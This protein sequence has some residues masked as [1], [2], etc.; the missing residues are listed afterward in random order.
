MMVR[1]NPDVSPPETDKNQGHGLIIVLPYCSASIYVCIFKTNKHLFSHVFIFSPVW[2]PVVVSVWEQ[3][4]VRSGEKQER[5]SRNARWGTRVE[6]GMMQTYV[7]AVLLTLQQSV[8]VPDSCSVFLGGRGFR[9]PIRTGV[10]TVKIGGRPWPIGASR[11]FV[12]WIWRSARPACWRAF[13]LMFHLDRW[14]CR[15]LRHWT[16]NVQT[17]Y[18]VSN[19]HTN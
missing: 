11:Q 1:W 16:L 3:T 10:C 13:R 12:W 14:G 6:K 19:F 5:I 2:L 7:R 15:S 18:S 9:C 4:A 17:P 8:W